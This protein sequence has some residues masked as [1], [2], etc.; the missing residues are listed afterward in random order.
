MRCRKMFFH[1]FSCTNPFINCDN[2]IIKIYANTHY[3][4]L[5]PSH[6][7]FS[8]S[9]SLS[10]TRRKREGVGEEEEEEKEKRRRKKIIVY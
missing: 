3:L 2:R 4:L 8:F 6:R 9:S 5:F 10:E 1:L 7:L